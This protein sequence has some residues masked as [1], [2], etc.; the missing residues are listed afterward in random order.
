[1]VN[2]SAEWAYAEHRFYPNQLGV[3][4][5]YTLPTNRSLRDDTGTG[6]GATPAWMS[7]PA[8]GFTNMM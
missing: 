3:N 8:R 5:N 7:V 4:T 6:E 2:A 1:M